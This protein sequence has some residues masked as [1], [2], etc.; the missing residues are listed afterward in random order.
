[1][2][3]LD[4]HGARDL[5]QTRSQASALLAEPVRMVIIKRGQLAFE[6]IDAVEKKLISIGGDDEGRG[7][8]KNG[9]CQ[10][11]ENAPLAPASRD[12]AGLRRIELDD[13]TQKATAFQ[14]STRCDY[15]CGE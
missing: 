5:R 3:F 4:R 6:P 14:S 1:S 2:G 9:G 10:S 12:K 15:G 11:D 8:R 7:H 13:Q